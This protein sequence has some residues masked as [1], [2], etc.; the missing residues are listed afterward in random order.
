M[1]A[2]EN[3]GLTGLF[4]NKIDSDYEKEQNQTKRIITMQ[5]LGAN[6]HPQIITEDETQAYFTFG[7]LPEKA[8]GYKKI[9]Y[10]DLYPGIDV[11]FHFSQNS[12]AGFEYSLT[13][14]PGADLSAVKM[15][16]SGDIEK[17][18]K[19]ANGKLTIKTDVFLWK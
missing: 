12:K 11:T 4:W 16:F 14:K 1:L 10:R 15:Q 2:T 5:W 19:D 7:M 17:I 13:L 3:Q 8:L 9:I 18:K 6:P